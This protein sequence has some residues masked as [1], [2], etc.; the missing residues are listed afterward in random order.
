MNWKS[1]VLCGWGRTSYA[2]VLACTPKDNAEALDAM[3]A[4]DDRGVIVYAGG[5]S[6]GDVALNSD[7]RTVLTSG[8]NRIHSFNPDS[9]ELVCGPGVTFHDLLRNFL[10]T[11]YMAPVSPGTGFVSIGGAIANDVHGKN[12]DNAGSF[13]D[14]VRWIDLL[15]PTRQCVRISPND[16][17]DLFA[18]TV[19][20]I[21]LTGVILA[22]SF[23]M[24][25]VPSNSVALREER[26]TDLDDFLAALESV[27]SR[28]TFTV[29]WIDTLA[30]GG[31][32]GRGIL[33]TAEPAT[34]DFQGSAPKRWRIPVDF[35]GF[36]L[37]S[38]TVRAFNQLYYR[39]IPHE[40]RERHVHIERFLYPLDT[41]LDWN[42]IYGRRGFFQLQ[43][44]LPDDTSGLGLL[45]LLEEISRSRSGSF[46]AVLKT[47][48]G[49][50]K[51]YL[52][53]PMRGFTL[54]LDFP[55]KPGIK[56]LLERLES[57]TLDYGGRIYLAKDACLSPGAFRRMY[58][59]LNKFRSVLEEIDPDARMMSDLARRLKIRFPHR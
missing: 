31:Q 51:G 40:G 47:L 4:V 46:L 2:S 54:A 10:P 13:G 44:V 55:R 24:Q 5:R 43:C 39:R 1:T 33:E 29:G 12:H 52:S 50:G 32:L 20:G 53:F 30:R 36:A 38:W 35:P 18:A 17:P 57:I 34:V 9:G 14:H 42:R 27:R 7:G 59:G 25:K 11:G 15:L 16:H 22:V 19:G 45:R 21:G 41:I 58:P 28:K 8:L 3:G 6:Y 37:N 49:S 26:V 23:S 56:K 48:G